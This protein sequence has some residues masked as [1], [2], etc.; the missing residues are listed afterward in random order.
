MERRVVISS[1]GIVS[2]L[3]SSEETIL[4]S[5][6]TGKT[7]FTRSSIYPELPVCPVKDFDPKIHTGRCKELRYLNRGAQFSV[8]SAKNAIRNSRLEKDSLAAAGLFVGAAPNLDISGVFPE[9]ANGN[10]DISGLQALWILKFLPNTAASLISQLTGIMGENLTVCTACAATLQA[11]GEAF[12][13][14]KTGRLD[15]ALAGGGNSCISPGGL[16]AYKKAGALYCGEKE[17]AHAMR[18]FDGERGGFVAGEGGAFFVLEE[19]EHARRRGAPIYAEVCGYGCSLDAYGMT[20]PAADGESGRSVV[21]KALEEAG[22]PGNEIGFISSHGTSTV[23]NDEAERLI[24]E[25]IQGKGRP[26]VIALKSWIGH[27][28]PACGALE[29]ALAIV[30]M[31]NSFLPEIRNLE[32]PCSHVIDFVREPRKASFSSMLIENFGFGGQNCA[33][34]LRDLT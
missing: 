26:P 29:L 32:H 27:C 14:I 19:I 25:R 22:I 18:P 10:L 2:S 23:L 30:L 8:T 11:V 31:K 7:T 20:T 16:L 15:L 5:F 4:E 9:I 33:L 34:V 3:G 6:R 21:L 24:I 13:R 12:T 28:A 17:A 1:L